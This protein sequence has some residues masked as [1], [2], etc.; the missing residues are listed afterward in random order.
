MTTSLSIG[1]LLSVNSVPSAFPET[2]GNRVQRLRAA[3][4]EAR[5]PVFASNS[6]P[7]S[8]GSSAYPEWAQRDSNEVQQVLQQRPSTDEL[9]LSSSAIPPS[10][11]QEGS[12][13]NFQDTRLV[14][15]QQ[16]GRCPAP[17]VPT[18]KKSSSQL[19]QGWSLAEQDPEWREKSEAQRREIA[20]VIKDRWPRHIALS[21]KDESI[22]K[23]CPSPLQSED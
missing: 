12:R 21:P 13:F 18:F 14:S 16:G 9:G 11:S 22:E 15:S 8:E 23:V 10:R 1:S 20:L 5:E 7:L 6:T 3:V 2:A 19:L 4:E 17:R